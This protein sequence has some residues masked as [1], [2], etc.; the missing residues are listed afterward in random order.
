MKKPKAKFILQNDNKYKL[1]IYLMENATEKQ[2]TW[3]DYQ[4][5]ICSFNQVANWQ[6]DL[7]KDGF[8]IIK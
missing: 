1:E 7:I 6:I 5:Q 3:A 4:G 2:N 8:E